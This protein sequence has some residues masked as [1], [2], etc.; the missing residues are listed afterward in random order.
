MTVLFTFAVQKKDQTGTKVINI[1]MKMPQTPMKA[2][3]R[4]CLGAEM[5]RNITIYL[6][7]DFPFCFP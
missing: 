1:L 5:F 6:F 7:V 4:M 3:F 2:L